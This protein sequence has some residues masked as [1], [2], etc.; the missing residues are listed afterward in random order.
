MLDQPTPFIKRPLVPIFIDSLYLSMWPSKY[1]C[2]IYLFVYLF[3]LICIQ[4]RIN[5]EF[6]CDRSQWVFEGLDAFCFCASILL[7]S[8]QHSLP[9]SYSKRFELINLLYQCICNHHVNVNVNEADIVSQVFWNLFLFLNSLV[10]AAFANRDASK[11]AQSMFQTFSFLIYMC[12]GW[13][14]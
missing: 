2:F 6:L 10:M 12:I 5:I 4:F 8:I 14:L 9:L 3:S 7:E 1:R 13:E 11:H